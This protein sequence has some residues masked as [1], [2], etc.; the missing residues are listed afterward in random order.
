MKENLVNQSFD[1]RMYP[2]DWRFSATIVGLIR[3]FKY[4]NIKFNQTDDYIEYN[5]ED[6]TKEKYVEFADYD[7]SDKMKYKKLLEFLS[8]EEFDNNDVKEY[9][10]LLN[11]K[12]GKNNQSTC[13]K[14]L[15]NNIKFDLTNANE[16]FSLIK[17]NEKHI[18]AYSFFNSPEMYGKFCNNGGKLEFLSPITDDDKAPCRLQGY[19]V[20]L[21]RKSKSI[22]WNFD[23]STYIG[24][25]I[26]EFDFIPFAF[27]HSSK[28]IFV[29][30]NITIQS[31]IEMYNKI[32][33]KG[34]DEI[35]NYTLK[36]LVE[37]YKQI[38]KEDLTNYNVEIIYNGTHKGDKG[39]ENNEY[40]ETLLLNETA[41][42]TFQNSIGL[43]YLYSFF[44]TDL[45]LN[46]FDIFQRILNNMKFDD[47]IIKLIKLRYNSSTEIP[48]RKKT[49]E[50][51]ID[52]NYLNYGKGEY[53][54]D[55]KQK[56][57]Y[58]SAKEVTEFLIEK[59][60][61]NKIKTYRNKL[62]S[63]I[64]LNNKNKVLEILTHISN[65]TNVQINIIYD[66][67]EDFDKH[68]NLVYTFIMALEIKTKKDE[69]KGE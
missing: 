67:I 57:A 27:S 31:L 34:I 12:N 28:S 21:K 39:P 26:R 29:N 38:A 49:I 47:I 42:K 43:P 14:E 69:N 33:L 7:F 11:G 8:K 50:D 10:T 66:L 24:C 19:Y 20:D 2:S 22:C 32:N 18:Q 58:A 4:F 62:I 1:T 51:I 64:S 16:I 5:Q 55:K 53:T 13:V 46:F 17:E 9:N 25:D 44:N 68:K 37:S 59:N 54:M 60:A 48:P 52:L 35:N 30:N 15:L 3:Y 40:F 61:T 65:F 36:Y 6:L 41:I 56:V 45:D 63:A 23:K